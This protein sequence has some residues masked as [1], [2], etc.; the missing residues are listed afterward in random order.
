MISAIAPIL[1]TLF[2]L[3]LWLNTTNRA[4]KIAFPIITLGVYIPLILGALGVIPVITS[5][6]IALDSMVVGLV[7]WY[8]IM[9]SDARR[10]NFHEHQ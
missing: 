1:G 3:I 9:D 5:Y 4:C 10:E 6:V 7:T 2:A 8:A